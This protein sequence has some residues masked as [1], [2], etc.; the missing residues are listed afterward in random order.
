MAAVTD[1]RATLRPEVVEVKEL[2]KS[3]TRDVSQKR[4]WQKR[5]FDHV[6]RNDQ[7]LKE[8]WDYIAMNPV[9]EGYVTRPEFYPYT[10]FLRWE[11]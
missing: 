3:E 11:E 6:I 7:D 1:W 5:P 8:N 2:A 4:L 10:G 9:K